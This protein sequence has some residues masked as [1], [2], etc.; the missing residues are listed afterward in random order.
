M[1]C[2]AFIACKKRWDKLM[3]LTFEDHH[4][5][6]HYVSTS[7]SHYNMIFR[8]YLKLRFFERLHRIP[9]QN[10]DQIMKFNLNCTYADMAIAVKK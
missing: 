7:P 6:S 3:A 9:T 1:R 10:N 5:F 2:S 8:A 4:N